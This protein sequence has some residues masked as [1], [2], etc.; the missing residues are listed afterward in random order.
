MPQQKAETDK[1]A[2]YK[3][4]KKTT[5][6]VDPELHRALQDYCYQEETDMV[7]YIFEQLVKADLETKGFYP[8][9]SR[10]KKA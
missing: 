3:L 7:S 6:N 4:K 10:K 9:K 2:P 1:V 5:F 8:P